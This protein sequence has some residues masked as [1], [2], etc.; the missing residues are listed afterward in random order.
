MQIIRTSGQYVNSFE[1]YDSYFGLSEEE[2]GD[3]DAMPE[4]FA[5]EF[6]RVSFTYPGTEKRILDELSF[7][8]NSGKKFPLWGKTARARVP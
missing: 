5:I 7:K 2:Y 4:N 6:D 1:L 3:V 8:I